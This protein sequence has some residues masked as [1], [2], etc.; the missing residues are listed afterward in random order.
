[1]KNINAKK[2]GK[3]HTQKSVNIKDEKSWLAMRYD[4]SYG[5]LDKSRR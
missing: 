4:A 2:K 3:I 5:K 1:M